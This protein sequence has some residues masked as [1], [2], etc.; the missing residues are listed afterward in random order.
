MCR[1]A[2]YHG[3]AIPLE[4]IIVRP[5]HSLLSQSQHATEAKLAVNGDGFGIAWYA[6]HS[7]E[8]GLYRDVL[9]AWSD[10]NLPSLCRMI[11]APLFLA[12]VRASTIGET[13]RANCHPFTFQGWSFC[14]NGQIAAFPA[15]RRRMEA[16]LPDAHYAA[17]RGTTD[18]EMLFLTLMARGFADAPAATLRSVLTEFAPESDAAPNRVTCVMS[19]GQS[20]LAFRHA[21]DGKAPT[22]Y[23]S[24][25]LDNG[26]R[27]F[28]SEP[29]DGESNR[30]TAVPLDTLVVLRD[31]QVAEYPLL[32]QAA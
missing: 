12:H 26:G 29:L 8:P 32:A 31:G 19:D 27:A 5:R 25:T 3:P 24:G 7:A 1:I 6:P 17:R 2:A 18:S 30:W 13:S 20:L 21:S 10:G 23:L 11:T 16:A 28:A 9:P 22:L 14:H 15:L 4:N